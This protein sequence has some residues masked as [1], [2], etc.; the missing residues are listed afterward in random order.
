MKSLRLAFALLLVPASAV[1]AADLPRPSP[2]DAVQ[3]FIRGIETGDVDLLAGSFT[4][5][6][7]AFM[8]GESPTRVAGRA[9]IKAAF[10][11]ILPAGGAGPIT[12]RD[13]LVQEL[14]EVAIVTVHLRALPE[15]VVTKATT[16]PRRS[17]VLHWSEG[18]WRIVHLHA[19]NFRI[20][21]ATEPKP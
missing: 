5:N 13:V 11:R 21:P 19:S 8:P 4:D 9:E 10:Q 14:G 1:H 20:E 17:F 2:L 16:F 6:G 12:P 18:R 3:A 7:T 15:G